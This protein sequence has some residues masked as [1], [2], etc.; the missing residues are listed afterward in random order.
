[1]KISPCT[2]RLLTPSL[3]SFGEERENA[4][5]IFA[6]HSLFSVCERYYGDQVYLWRKMAKT[7]SGTEEARE[8]APSPPRSGGEGRGEVVVL[9][10]QGESDKQNTPYGG[11]IVFTCRSSGGTNRCCSQFLI[12]RT[13]PVRR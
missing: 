11:K 9:R 1:M 6:V 10:A 12:T 13:H 8:L 7:C 4:R 2:L 3:S 5:A